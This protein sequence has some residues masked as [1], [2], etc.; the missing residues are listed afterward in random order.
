M[1]VPSSIMGSVLLALATCA[2]ASGLDRSPPEADYAYLCDACTDAEYVEAARSLGAGRQLLFDFRADAPRAFDVLPSGSEA[3]PV[4]NAPVMDEEM[5]RFALSKRLWSGPGPARVD[6]AEL[7][8]WIR[9][10]GPSPSTAEMLVTSA[11]RNEIASALEQLLPALLPRDVPGAVGRICKPCTAN[12][13][14]AL[15]GDHA[16]SVALADG[17]VVD[18]ATDTHEMLR[19]RAIHDAS[20]KTWQFDD[21]GRIVKN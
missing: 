16:I 10:Q 1:N 20:G 5:R 2:R 14:Q 7:A 8:G 18:F 9:R 11:Y 19:V 12:P 21:A 13:I 4:A 6:R 17:G 15:S 3:N